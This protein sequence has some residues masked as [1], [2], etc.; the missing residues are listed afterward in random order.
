MSE[1][2]EAE[3]DELYAADFSSA[4]NLRYFPDLPYAEGYSASVYLGEEDPVDED[5][6]DMLLAIAKANEEPVAAEVDGE[7]DPSVSV[8]DENVRAATSYGY[9]DITEENRPAWEFAEWMSDAVNPWEFDIRFIRSIEFLRYTPGGFYIPHC[10]WGPEHAFRKVSFVLSL[11]SLDEYE[12]GELQVYPGDELNEFRLDKGD[13]VSFPSFVT[14]EVRPVTSGE[15]WA[16]V[17]WY[18]GP[19]LR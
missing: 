18:E 6:C 1:E 15:R 4:Y 12:G 3:D 14:H 16:M 8:L 2:N 13:W 17:V 10:D 19:P 11:S 5:T 9:A 7:D